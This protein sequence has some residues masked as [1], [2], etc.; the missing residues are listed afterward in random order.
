MENSKIIVM[1]LWRGAIC[2]VVTYIAAKIH[3]G[4]AVASVA[5][6]G[7]LMAKPIIEIGANW[8]NWAKRE[9]YAKW[10]GNYFE[11]ANVQIRIFEEREKLLFVAAD[12]LKVLDEKP[13]KAL[14]TMYS[15]AEVRLMVEENLVVFSE[16]GVKKYLKSSR[17]RESGPMLLWIERE[18]IKPHQRK[19]EIKNTPPASA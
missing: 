14:Q 17:H 8:F 18:I 3:P 9:P 15:H 2:G 7:A 6:W 10:Q 4:A 11:F 16:E 13:S 12:V 1:L 5:L 19:C